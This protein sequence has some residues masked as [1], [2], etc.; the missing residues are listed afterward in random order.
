LS[1]THLTRADTLPIHRVEARP[2]PQASANDNQPG[3]AIA[4][5]D[6]KCLGD[7]LALAL[8]GTGGALT[9]AWSGVLAWGLWKV[10]AFVV[11]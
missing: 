2:V 9:L 6:R 5:A 3:E 10:L 1:A 11:F 7:W 8:L 4:G